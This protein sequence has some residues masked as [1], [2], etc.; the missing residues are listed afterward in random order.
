LKQGRLPRTFGRKQVAPAL[1]MQRM[2]V[3]DGSP[4]H[5][6]EHQLP[7]GPL[8]Q[9]DLLEQ[10]IRT[11][12]LVPGAKDVDELGSCTCQAGTTHLAER[13]VAAGRE[14]SDVCLPGASGKDWPG[15][16]ETDSVTNEEFAILLYH[17]VTDQTGELA[18][19]WPPTDSGSSGYYV[20]TE[21]ERRKYAASYKSASGVTGA[22]SL[23]QS[24]TVMQGT[25]FFE[26]WLTPDTQG[27]ID[28]D[29]S[30]DALEAAVYSGVAGGHETLQYAIP[31]LAQAADGT[32]NLQQTVIRC[33][34][35]WSAQWGLGGDFLVHASTLSYLAQYCDFKALVV[36]AA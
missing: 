1:Q 30:L 34:N 11:S 25:P 35:S 36:G 28:G 3:H 10:G 6:I 12:Q 17:L 21:L 33:R 31:Q 23:L 26:A 24:G 5:E 7:F 19:E 4:L 2:H 14:L 15:L 22:L 20:C 27:F 32:V 18:E 8:D 9:E 16:S 13:W 29:G